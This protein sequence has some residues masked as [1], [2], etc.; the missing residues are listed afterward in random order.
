MKKH[1]QDIHKITANTRRMI[2]IIALGLL[3]TGITAAGICICHDAMYGQAGSG[4]A[5]SEPAALQPASAESAAGEGVT[6][7]DA[8]FQDL[9]DAVSS[10]KE[11]TARTS[12]AGTTAGLP[13]D[14]AQAVIS[15]TASA[16]TRV[17]VMNGDAPDLTG[18]IV[19]IDPGH[20]LY[21]NN[22]QEAMAPAG[23]GVEG[24]KEK[25]SSGTSG[26]STKR[27]EY[28]VNLEV[29]L[30][31]CSYLESLGCEVHMTRT[32]DDVDLSNIDR[33]DIAHSYA[34]DYYIRLHCDGSDNASARGIGVFVT[35]LGDNAS[36]QTE[37]GDIL[38]NCLA[39]STGAVF[40]GTN[41]GTT[42][43]GLNWTYDIPGC[44][45]EMGFM[46][47]PEEDELLSDPA[48]Q[49]QICAGIA[50]FLATLPQS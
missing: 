20:Q 46:T 43:S 5:S 11:T 3:L 16:G 45:L 28:E 34:T 36:L 48:Y 47:N 2:K 33:A 30:M 22:E 24:T 49:Q 14:T 18:Y 6:V 26:V 4:S 42:Y 12:A 8:E 10:F 50:D 25:C 41:A 37:L 44:I 39:E 23:M 15:E 1:K 21:S 7:A 19:V 9:T 35:S 38:G 40:R 27:P 29:G 13:S 31:L 32:T 17:P